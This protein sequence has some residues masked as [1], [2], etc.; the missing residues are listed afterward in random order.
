MRKHL[1]RLGIEW[2]TPQPW[3]VMD[4]LCWESFRTNYPEDFIERVKECIK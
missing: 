1:D 2:N 3:E 4:Q